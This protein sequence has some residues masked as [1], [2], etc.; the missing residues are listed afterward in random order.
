V[1]ILNRLPYYERP[2]LLNFRDRSVEIR[3]YQ[4]AIWV[5]LR[6]A[7]FPAVLDSGDSHNFSIPEQLLRSWASVESL[8][9][10]GQIE[11]NRQILTQYRNDL[12]LHRNKPGRREPSDSAHSLKLGEGITIVPEGTPNAP[13]LP[14]LALRAISS[15]RLILTIDGSRNQV[16]LKTTGWF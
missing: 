5:R 3:G 12:W 16:S 9:P 15:N 6:A 11:V 8:E 1:K 14:L 10:I 13:R 4:I 7:V 2:T